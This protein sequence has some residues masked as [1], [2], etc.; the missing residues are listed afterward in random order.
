VGITKDCC[1]QEAENNLDFEEGKTAFT[2][3]HKPHFIGEEVANSYSLMTG[4][5]VGKRSHCSIAEGTLED[6]TLADLRE[7]NCSFTLVDKN[8]EEVNHRNRN[9]KEEAALYREYPK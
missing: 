7:R 5:E 4:P 2:T 6:C 3:S 8:S 9:F 1:R